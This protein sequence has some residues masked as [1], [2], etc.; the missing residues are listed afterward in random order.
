MGIFFNNITFSSLI[1]IFVLVGILVGINEITRR[2]KLLSIIVYGLTPIILLICIKVDIFGSPSGKT[3]FGWIKVVSALIGV[4]GFILIRFTKM[5]GSKFI[6]WFPVTILALNILEAVYKDVE[7]FRTYKTLEIDAAGVAVLG[8]PWNIMNAIAG[9]LCILTLSGFAKIEISKD[10][11]RDM[12]WPD[13]TWMYIV[14]YTLWNFA[15]VYNCIS[16]RVMY[17][18]FAIL[19]SAIVAEYVFKRG[20]WLQHRAQ[21]LSLFAMFSLCIDYQSIGYFQI[22]PNYTE[23]NLMIISGVAMVFNMG[24]F[25]YMIYNM[26]KYK[27]NPTKESVNI[28]TKGYKKNISMNNL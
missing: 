28:H 19:I 3:W 26:Y 22:T 2:S 10:K 17:A 24:V 13:M 1:M 5:R 15:Y 4:W 21:T 8:G 14:G 20:A 23:T 6:T 25:I 7:V 12:I 16:T 11:S 9:V 18:G 27:I